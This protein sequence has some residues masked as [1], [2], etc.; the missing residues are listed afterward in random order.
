[1]KKTLTAVLI[2]TMCISGYS[3]L[4]GTYFSEDF[5]SYETVFTDNSA[6]NNANKYNGAAWQIGEYTVSNSHS[7]QA[8]P[9]PGTDSAWINKVGTVNGTATPD[10]VARLSIP[11][12]VSGDFGNQALEINNNKKSQSRNVY[13]VLPS[14]AVGADSGGIVEVS[15]KFMDYNNGTNNFAIYGMDE[16]DVIFTLG[17][18]GT[19]AR[20]ANTI[21]Y[22][23]LNVTVAQ[24]SRMWA[25][26]S[27][28]Q[29]IGDLRTSTGQS[30][31]QLDVAT[32]LE[33]PDGS[34]Y[35]VYKGAKINPDSTFRQAPSYYDIAMTL[36]F[37]TQTLDAVC[38]L[39]KRKVQNNAIIS[40]GADEVKTVTNF[41]FNSSKTLTKFTKF[42]VHTNY[43]D[44]FAQLYVDD[45]VVRNPDVLPPVKAAFSI[46]SA[47][48]SFAGGEVTVNSEIGKTGDYGT[49]AVIA[50][51]YGADGEL[52]GV[53]VESLIDAETDFDGGTMSYTKSIS[54]AGGLEPQRVAL[55]L[56][57]SVASMKQIQSVECADE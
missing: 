19:P 37:N 36:N 56:W 27:H 33:N 31:L 57:D 21:Y 52:I 5:E 29:T 14:S 25:L 35:G 9:V 51:I 49:A 18:F 20:P 46:E 53:D 47:E 24:N 15:F 55:Y 23:L 41:P 45:I 7:G 44:A 28:F 40:D 38:T 6:S 16:D 10:A 4:A 22:D 54:V 32:P 12:D 42:N 48:Y 26:D 8:V 13:R 34:F 11:L 50:A 1:M 3:A 30:V 17:L 39:H 43:V 2:I